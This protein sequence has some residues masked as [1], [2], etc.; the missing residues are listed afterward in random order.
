M[1]RAISISATF[2]AGRYHGEEWPPSPARL[3][4]ALVAGAKTGAY[5]SGWSEAEPAVRWLESR[6]AP[7]IFAVPELALQRYRL[8]VPNNDMDV[9]AKEWAA[10]KAAD[11]A[12]L[13]TMK[14]VS[15]RLVDGIGP[16]VLYCWSLRQGE[17]LEA[18][19]AAM[20][21]LTRSLSSFGWGVDMA[22]AETEI[23]E[24]PMAQSYEEWTPTPFRG[25]WLSVPVPGFLDD[26]EATYERFVNR[27]EKMDTDTRPMV[28]RLQRYER[29]GKAAC[30]YAS[31]GLRTASGDAVWSKRWDENIE[32]AAWLRHASAQALT[33]EVDSAKVAGFVLGHSQPGVDPAFRVSYVPLPSIGYDHAD[34]RI[35]R[36]ILVEPQSADGSTGSRLGETLIGSVLTNSGGNPACTLGPLPDEKVVDFYTRDARTWRSVTPVVLH[37]FNSRSGQI[38]MSKTDALLKRAFEM[39]GHSPGT[40][41]S[42]AFQ[43]APFWPGCG[44]AREARVPQHLQNYP[45]YH[46]EVRFRDSV[47]G[48][49]LA[50]IGRHF[51]LGVFAARQRD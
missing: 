46:V 20:R 13:R 1:V 4:R 6:P 18:I 3:L 5:R 32:V 51:G 48:P 35:R 2:L 34:G 36:V 42:I 26:L 11:P 41:E 14:D 19:A 29:T 17:D 16:H 21:V 12:A 44:S 43:S 9:V 33:G 31:F 38:S 30:P 8:A 49:I 22:Y 23:V 24:S 40:I 7:V 39:A 15:P 47:T 45:R 10:G 25:K 50:G 37:G 28:Y 27:L